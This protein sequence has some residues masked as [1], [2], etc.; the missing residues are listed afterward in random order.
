[1]GIVG[2]VELPFCALVGHSAALADFPIANIS[3]AFE[4]A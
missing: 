3:S 1:M 4:Q 2:Q